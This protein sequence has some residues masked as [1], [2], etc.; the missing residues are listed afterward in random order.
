MPELEGSLTP[1]FQHWRRVKVIA[2]D[3]T[4][5]LGDWAAP[6]AGLGRRDDLHS[7]YPGRCLILRG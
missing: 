1:A 7:P 2:R 6:F 5:W 4:L 3:V